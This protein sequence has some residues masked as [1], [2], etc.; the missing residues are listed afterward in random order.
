MLHFVYSLDCGR[1]FEPQY[2]PRLTGFETGITGR[3]IHLLLLS[4][5]HAQG[6]P[7][8]LR[9]VAII[10]NKMM[11]KNALSEQ[12]QNLIEKS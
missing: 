9:L 3:G 11:G 6:L 1:D 4:R 7:P 12:L 5:Y 8:L 10:A 2:P